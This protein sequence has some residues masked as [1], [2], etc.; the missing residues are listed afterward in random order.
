MMSMLPRARAASTASSTIFWMNGA[1]RSTAAGVKALLTSRR[2]RVCLG[3]SE[4]S[5]ELLRKADSSR[6]S[7]GGSVWMT[8]AR[9]DETL[10]LRRSAA[11]SA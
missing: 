10:G 7:S 5:I 6:T 11:T 9:S 4:L 1:R 3:G 8:R 2:R